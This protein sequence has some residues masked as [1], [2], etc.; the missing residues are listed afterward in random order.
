MPGNVAIGGGSA[1]VT[2]TLRARPSPWHDTNATTL[3]VYV[4]GLGSRAFDLTTE[5]G[6]LVQAVWTG[7]RRVKRKRARRKGKKS[8]RGARKR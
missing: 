7:V 8:R 6:R 4:R 2:H 1:T 5:T 3:R